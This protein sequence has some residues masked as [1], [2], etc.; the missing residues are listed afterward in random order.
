MAAGENYE[1][2]RRIHLSGNKIIMSK[3]LNYAVIQSGYCVFG[4][5]ST[6]GEAYAD[7]ANWLEPRKSDNETYTPEM[8]A[9]ECA[10]FQ[11]D[12]DLKLIHRNND[13]PDEFDSYMKNQGGY[14]FDGNSWVSDTNA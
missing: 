11:F 12:G 8:V 2:A 6:P 13:D 10:D 3:Y 9:D 1:P 7:A 4:A 14:T 5:G